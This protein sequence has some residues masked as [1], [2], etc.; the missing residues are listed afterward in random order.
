VGTPLR[1]PVTCADGCG[2]T[3]V[4]AG[5]RTLYPRFGRRVLAD[6]GGVVGDRA[7]FF[8]S[9]AGADRAWVAWLLV[10]A[11]YTVVLWSAQIAA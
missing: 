9:H 7:G 4:E 2:R 11:G 3:P 10:Q 5:Q 6:T 1:V 8:V